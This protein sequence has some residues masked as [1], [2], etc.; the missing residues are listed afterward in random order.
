MRPW[1]HYI[2]VQRD[3]SDL[4]D[5]VAWA[6]RNPAAAKKI[7]D[8]AY[9]FAKEHLTREAA[10]KQFDRVVRNIIKRQRPPRPLLTP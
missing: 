7:A 4:M 8:Q 3:L 2:P 9:E 10:W 6:I 1:Q 5:R